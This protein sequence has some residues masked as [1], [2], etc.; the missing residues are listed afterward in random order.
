MVHC[1]AFKAGFMS[2]SYVGNTLLH[3]YAACGEIGFAWR[4]FDEM[5][6]RNVVS[7]SSMIGGYVLCNHPFEALTVFKQMQV[8]NVQPNSVT[9]ELL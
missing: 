9:L 5:S 8:A 4:V 1:L 7:W 2:D 6:E 3:M